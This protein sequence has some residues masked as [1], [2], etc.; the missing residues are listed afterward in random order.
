MPELNNK[1]PFAA[2]YLLLPNAQGIDTLYVNVK[3]SF[4][5]GRDWT[6]CD[7]QAEPLYEDAYWGEPGKSSLKYPTSVHQGK[8]STD[9]AILGH[10]WAPNRQPVKQLDV[11]ATVGSI[12]KVLRV[13]GDRFWN[14]G[15]I[16]P[17][18]DFIQIPI[19]YENAYGG[20]HWVKDQLLSLEPRNPVGKGFRGT[21]KSEEM[22]GQAL[23]N[24]E[25]PKCLIK[26]LDDSPEP[27]GF[28]FMSANWHPRAL[29]AG[30]Y[31]EQWQKNR[32]PY[33]P[34]D[35]QPRFQNS[36][37][38]EL[39]SPQYLTGGESVTLTNMHPDGVINF[40]LPHVYLGGKVLFRGTPE[41]SLHFVMETLII[42]VDTMQV[43]IDWK[44]SCLCNNAFPLLNSIHVYL[45]R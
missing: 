29:F 44:A 10:A 39:I 31:D 26:D 37:H 32:A 19:R 2:G 4:N 16:S 21:R 24:I 6:L 35:Y 18:R 8:P 15:R 11:V 5:L 43:T 12:K 20:Q 17:P 30:T 38:P 7:E 9:I 34:H 45:L 14:S 25:N 27:A 40:F 23:P 33:L 28:G 13:F 42:D 36:A 41:Q 3:A 22:D 1:T